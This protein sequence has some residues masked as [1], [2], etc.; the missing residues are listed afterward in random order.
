MSING[1]NPV[2]V[3]LVEDEVLI[4]MMIAGM[5][6]ELGHRV[7]AE[8]SNIRVALDLAKTA[9]FQFAILDINVGGE[10]IDPVAD[11]IACRAV[12]FIFASGYGA[13]GA[14]INFRDRTVLQKPFLI[15]TLDHAIRE[16]LVQVGK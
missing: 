10:K 3:L 11:I 9:D 1:P 15:S 5:I 12:P 14:P 8:A 6:E 7:V 13:I 4:G 16:T 2:S